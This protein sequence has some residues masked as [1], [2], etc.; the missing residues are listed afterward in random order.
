MHANCLVAHF[1]YAMS[2]VLHLYTDNY[3]EIIRKVVAEFGISI[4]A[5]NKD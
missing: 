4:D 1:I 5:A 2:K 3:D